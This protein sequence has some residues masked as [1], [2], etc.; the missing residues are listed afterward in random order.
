MNFVGKVVLVTGASRGIGKAIALEFA[1]LGASVIINYKNDDKAAEE[2]LKEIKDNGGYSIAIK[3]D[4]SSYIF[5]NKMIKEIIDKFGKID[6]L[7]NNAGISKVGLFIDMKEEEFD[8]IININLKGVFNTCHN[9][10]KYMISQRSGSIIN[11]SSIWGGVGASCEVIYSASKGG[12]NS[13][14]KALG[15]EFA[16]S[17]IRVN[18]IEPGVIDTEMNRWMSQEERSKLEEEIPMMRFGNGSDI[19]KLATFLASEQSTYITAQ[20]ITVDGGYL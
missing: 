5:T 15:K 16:S 2:T 4:V 14:T 6:V 12:I 10:A 8:N 18:A 17:G 9:V 7:V 3:G 20:V 11:I 19:G 1:K 13:F